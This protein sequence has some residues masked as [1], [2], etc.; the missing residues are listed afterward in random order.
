M[1]RNDP[2]YERVFAECMARKPTSI[3]DVRQGARGRT[4]T[5]AEYLVLTGVDA[6]PRAHYDSWRDLQAADLS[7]NLW[8]VVTVRHDRTILLVDTEGY[9]YPRY[10]GI[11]Y[12]PNDDLL[13][14]I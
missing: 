11:I 3:E 6:V 7:A 13:S 14:E 8:W 5:A 10:A 2:V 12:Q 9:E 4:I 1:A